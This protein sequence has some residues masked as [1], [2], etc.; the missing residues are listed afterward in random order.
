M[1]TGRFDVRGCRISEVNK[2]DMESQGL[3]FSIFI[4][5]ISTIRD[6]KTK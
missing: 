1:E 5:H 2:G 3:Y 6:Q 4:L